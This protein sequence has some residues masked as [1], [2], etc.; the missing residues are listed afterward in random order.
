MDIVLLLHTHSV[1]IGTVGISLLLHTH[2]VAI[3]TVGISLLLVMQD[4]GNSRDEAC[5]V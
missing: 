2:S 4:C 3:G 5:S 1:A